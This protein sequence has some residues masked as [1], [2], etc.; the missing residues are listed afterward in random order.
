MRVD[1]RVAGVPRF[2]TLPSWNSSLR[3]EYSSLL[4]II[5][6]YVSS[7]SMGVHARTIDN[8]CEYQ[9]SVIRCMICRPLHHKRVV[10]PYA[11]T[12]FCH[13]SSRLVCLFSN[14]IASR[15]K[16]TS[17][18]AFH[19]DH[20]VWISALD[21]TRRVKRLSSIVVPAKSSIH[22]GIHPIVIE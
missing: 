12:V 19:G 4:S 8:I 7:S 18:Q 3:Y 15:M 9:I 2:Q 14:K 5:Y 16:E 6:I 13:A 1:E 20:S 21:H 22:G 10:Q 17:G 11:K